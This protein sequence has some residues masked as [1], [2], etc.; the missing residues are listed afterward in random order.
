MS[1]GEGGDAAARYVAALSAASWKVRWQAAQ[2]L[3]ELRDARA[4]PQLVQ[5]LGDPNQWVRIVAAEALG[6]IGDRAATPALVRALEDESVWVRRACVVALGQIGDERAVE[7]LLNHLLGPPDHQWPQEVRHAIARALGA[8]GRTAIRRLV[9]ALDAADPWVS[10]AAA[11]AL[12]QI[13]APEAILP[14]TRL[15]RH[16]Q[17]WVR[18]AATRALA[19]ITDG[20]AVRAALMTDEAPQVFWKL[21]ALKEIGNATL[22]QLTGLLEDSDEAVRARAAEVLQQLGAINEEASLALTLRPGPVAATEGI[23]SLVAALGDPV[24][25]VRLAAAEALGK[26]GDGRVV[27]ALSRL[28]QDGDSRVRAAAA[29]SLGEIMEHRA[30]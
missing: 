1:L 4:V 28:L 22:Q 16:P 3:G 17:P 5:A 18:S 27:P 8:I 12:G 7:P 14:L 6:Q 29:R 23:E 2:A 10:G 11:Q 20:R 19:R 26:V 24:A 15:T 30:A 25:D 9:A 21:M 13:G